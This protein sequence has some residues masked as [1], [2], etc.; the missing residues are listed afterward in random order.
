MASD[1]IIR[2]LS[3]FRSKFVIPPGRLGGSNVG[4]W[5]P[6]HMYVSLKQMQAKLRSVDCVVEVHDARIPFSG[7]NEQFR[8]LL[9]S[10]RP[11]ILVLNKCDLI[12]AKLQTRIEFQLREKEKNLSHILW[13]NCKLKQQSSIKRLT[14]AIYESIE[15]V[16]RFNRE[17]RTHYMLMV[18]GKR[19]FRFWT[20][21]E[22]P[23]H[24]AASLMHTDENAVGSR[25]RSVKFCVPPAFILLPLGG[26][27]G[28]FCFTLPYV[29][30]YSQTLRQFGR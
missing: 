25:W 3:Q 18:I 16:P 17:A 19:L 7:R 21:S 13:T 22:D 15:N 14:S 24:S 8:N 2:S 20:I 1:K 26:A 30:S 5:F 11:H 27:R 9:Y 4:K 23:P 29:H 12:D 10:I 28:W 6:T